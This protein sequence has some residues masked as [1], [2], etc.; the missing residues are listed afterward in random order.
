MINEIENQK[1]QKSRNI[2]RKRREKKE[3]RINSD[4]KLKSW[5]FFFG[6]LCLILFM[7]KIFIC[8]KLLN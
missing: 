8:S 7:L 2:R 4:N 6:V 1:E 3:D 5:F